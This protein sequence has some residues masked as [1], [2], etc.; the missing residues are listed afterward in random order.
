MLPELRLLIT[1][2]RFV[3]TGLTHGTNF[4]AVVPFEAVVEEYFYLDQ[5]FG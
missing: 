4:P 5:K 2:S 1:D 3:C